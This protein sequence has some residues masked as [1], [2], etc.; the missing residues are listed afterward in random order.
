[1]AQVSSI[2]QSRHVEAQQAF[3]G[4]ARVYTGLKR[5][6]RILEPRQAWRM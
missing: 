3:G 2:R 4:V 1:M 5:R 6:N